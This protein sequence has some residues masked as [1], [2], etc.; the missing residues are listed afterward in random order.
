MDNWFRDDYY[1][2]PEMWPL[3][4][5][6]YRPVFWLPHTTFFMFTTV[7]YDV[8]AV[9]WQI[10]LSINLHKGVVW[11]YSICLTNN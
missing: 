7:E 3:A 11:R 5:S 8:L 10:K 6:L 9:V 4:N 2:L 1:D